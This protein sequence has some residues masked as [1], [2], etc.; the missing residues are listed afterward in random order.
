MVNLLRKIVVR[1]TGISTIG[2]DLAKFYKFVSKLSIET[3]KKVR[4]S[5]RPKNF[6]ISYPN[7]E[8]NIELVI[9][10]HKADRVLSSLTKAKLQIISDKVEQLENFDP[11]KIQFI[12]NDNDIWEFNY[13]LAR[14]GSVIGTLSSFN[15][16]NELYNNIL[17]KQKEDEEKGNS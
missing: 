11:E 14:D 2:S 8:C 13:L 17:V 1:L 6:V 12:Y 15:K 10:T 9:T 5:Y 16:R 3:I 4:P 7:T